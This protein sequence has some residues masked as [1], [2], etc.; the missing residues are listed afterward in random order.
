[1]TT[2]KTSVALGKAELAA[3]KRAAAA[4]GSS[5]SAFLTKLVRAHVAQA[6]RF[7]AMERYLMKH[8]PDFRLTGRARAAVESEWTAPLKPVRVRPRRKRTAA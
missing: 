3:A 1:M 2:Q 5:L 4:E 6:A 8:A 7:D